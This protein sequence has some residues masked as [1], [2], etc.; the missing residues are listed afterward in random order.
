MERKLDDAR[1]SSNATTTTTTTRGASG[2]FVAPVK[3]VASPSVDEEPFS[4]LDAARPR[5]F[6]GFA[7]N[8]PAIEAW[9]NAEKFTRRGLGGAVTTLRSREASRRMFIKRDCESS[10]EVFDTAVKRVFVNGEQV[11]CRAALTEA[12]AKDIDVS[13]VAD[14][15]GLRLKLENCGVWFGSRSNVTPLHYDLCHGFLI[16]IK[17]TKT[18]TMFHK[19]DYRS[20]YQ[21][22]DRPELSRVDLDAWLRGNEEERDRFPNF[23]DASPHLA[24][25]RPGDMIY[26]PPFFWHHV[27]THD[28]E[29]A[30]SV[31]IPFDM[32]PDEEVHE[33]HLWSG[34]F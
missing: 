25:L 2:A 3:R 28:D 7:A 1:A 18:F 14:L 23:E 33:C 26:T 30:I 4:V 5:L 21:R 34:G 32:R 17:G 31:L 27:R 13:A 16:M 29:A 12:L 20:M 10:D 22:K 8:A 15:C 6:K 24:T 19:D 9:A 11:Y